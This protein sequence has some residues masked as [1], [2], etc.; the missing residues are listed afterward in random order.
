MGAELRAVWKTISRPMVSW[1][2]RRGVWWLAAIALGYALK[3]VAFSTYTLAGPNSTLY[4]ILEYTIPV[5]LIAAAAGLLRLGEN[6]QAQSGPGLVVCS[7]RGRSGVAVLM[8]RNGE[9]CGGR[10]H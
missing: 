7:A 6:E 2:A 10:E 3:L 8:Q 1:W 9:A 4:V 5:S